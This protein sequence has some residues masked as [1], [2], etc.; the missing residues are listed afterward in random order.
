M[1]FG[2]T[3]EQQD[4]VRDAAEFLDKEFFSKLEHEQVD[5]FSFH[6]DDTYLRRLDEELG[7]TEK[8][9][10][11]GLR[12]V[13]WPVAYGGAGRSSI[14]QWLYSEELVYRRL[15]PGGHSVSSVGA[16]I[17]RFGTDEQKKRFLRAIQ[18]GRM[19]LAL[20]YTEPNAG[21]DLGSIET[22]AVREGDS[23]VVNGQK[24]YTT[25]AHYATHIWLAA[26]TGTVASRE[27]GLSVFVVPLDSPG[28]S[29]RPL[30]TQVDLRSN[31][32][33][34]DSVR[35]SARDRIGNENEGWPVMR[36]A[37]DLEML[38]PYSG[39]RHDLDD[40]IE[41]TRIAQGPGGIPLIE[42]PVV[43]QTLARLVVDLEVARLLLMRTVWVASVSGAT[44]GP[45]KVEAAMAKVWLSE[46]QRRV[47]S[48]GLALMGAQ[49]QL[50]IASEGAPAGG[51]LEKLFRY[52]PVYIFGSGSNEILRDVIA[53]AGLRLPPTRTA[54]GEPWI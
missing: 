26:R 53:Q 35:I 46:L 33:F 24:I 40:L 18:Q 6:Y 5:P 16:T 36:M 11:K 9:F 34:L 1:D 44:D 54:E 30:Y 42:D 51:R 17:M 41:W 8:L 37:L 48:E 22:R 45:P 12:G 31:E 28:I 21:T 4:F 39:L 14:E 47:A 7:Y 43:R 13:S 49:G 52:C 20:G 27:M 10:N 25:A 50:K 32:V 38:R 23:Y 19:E 2:V 15:P 3:Q 29:V